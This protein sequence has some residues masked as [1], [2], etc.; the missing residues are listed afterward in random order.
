MG[1][2]IFAGQAVLA[3]SRL[4]QSIVAVNH[5]DGSGRAGGGTEQ[6][7]VAES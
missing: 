7:T 4:H 2:Y 5:A 1:T 6:S 3:S